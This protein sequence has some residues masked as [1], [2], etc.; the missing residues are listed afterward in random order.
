MLPISFVIAYTLIKL[1][2]RI[3]KNAVRIGAVIV[4]CA[5][6]IFTGTPVF[7]EITTA[8]AVPTFSRYLRTF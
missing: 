5:C 8:G 4:A 6:I 7:L 1:V 3:P 2:Y